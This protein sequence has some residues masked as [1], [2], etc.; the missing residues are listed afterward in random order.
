VFEGYKGLTDSI[1]ERMV[2]SFV[3]DLIELGAYNRDLV[4]AYARQTKYES[5]VERLK[6]ILD[7]YDATSR[8]G[9]ALPR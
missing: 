6:K 7:S 4:L 9:S 2:R 3:D 5:S 1:S 8:R